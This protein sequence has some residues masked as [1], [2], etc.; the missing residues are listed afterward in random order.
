MAPGQFPS[1]LHIG[2][3]LQN[4]H[5]PP[6]FQATIDDDDVSSAEFLEVLM[7][8]VCQSEVIVC[9]PELPETRSGSVP[10]EKRRSRA[11][12]AGRVLSGDVPHI[13]AH[14][15]LRWTPLLKVFLQDQE[16]ELTALKALGDLMIRMQHPEGVCLRCI[17]PVHVTAVLSDLCPDVG[18]ASPQACCR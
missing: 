6:A 1:R 18:P 12:R 10:E 17:F 15:M 2:V 5:S 11:L 7:T 8:C 14:S 4:P 13:D 16:K 9:K 3:Q